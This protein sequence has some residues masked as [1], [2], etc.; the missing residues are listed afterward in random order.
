MKLSVCIPVYNY[1]ARPLV[2]SLSQQASAFEGEVEL[3]CIDDASDTSWREQAGELTELGS[4][5]QLEENVGRARIR[6]MFLEHTQGD[7][8]LFL[9]VDSEVGEGF[10]A[11]YLEAL[12]QEPAVV[13][14]GRVYDRRC[15]DQAHRL[16]YLYGTQVESRPVKWRR[17]HPYQSFMSNNFA[18][19]RE[20]LEANPFDASITRYGHEDTL[21]G[22]RLE[23][24]GVP[25]MHIDNPVVNGEVEENGVFLSKT[26]EAVENLAAIDDALGADDAF[27]RRVRLV[28]TYRRLRSMGITG[29]VS[30]L[31]SLLRRPLESHFVSGNSV[32]V[33]QLNFYKLGVFIKEKNKITQKTNTMK[34]S[35][36]AVALLM[37]G[38]FAAGTVCAQVM[39]TK[40]YP[41]GSK[42]TGQF[43]DKGRLKQGRGRM[44]WTDGNMYE[45]QWMKDKPHGEG[46]FT[47]A[48]GIVYQGHWENNVAKGH[49]IITMP[50]G[51]TIEGEWVEMGD[52]TG[53]AVW[54]DGTRYEGPFKGGA[55]NGYGVKVWPNGDRYEGNFNMGHMSGQGTMKYHDGSSYTGNWSSDMYNGLGK[56]IAVDGSVTEGNFRSGKLQN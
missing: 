32:S 5:L 41:D 7:Y 12:E 56:Y 55:A 49:G 40:T 48:N 35:I 54:S 10:L 18:V 30:W 19:R 25:I 3:V 44:V 11:R 36:K 50:N 15:N 39:E 26:V 23:Q 21:F 46:T 37:L 17:S 27:G 34:T 31:H 6:N 43:S 28:G 24:N 53:V 13:V 1:D 52:G 20:V 8:L 33:A 51:C 14:G 9:D 38:M 29:P 45:G 42:Y 2:R 22:F 4:Y 47:F 16:R